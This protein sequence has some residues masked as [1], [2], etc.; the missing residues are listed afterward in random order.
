MRCNIFFLLF[1]FISACSNPKLTLDTEKVPFNELLDFI[2]AEQDKIQTLQ[3]ACRISVDSKEFSGN[4]F[5]SVNYTAN[6]S[7]HLSVSGPFGIQGG[8]LF[9]AKKR[10]VF[11]NQITNKFY[12]GTIDDFED[13]NFFQFPLNLK[14]LINIFSAKENL[15]SMKISSYRVD[16]DQFIIESYKQSDRY[17]ISVDPNFGHITRVEVQGENGNNIVREYSNFVK[18]KTVYFPRKIDM[19]RKD[20]NQAVSI[21]YTQFSLNERIEPARFRVKIA[22]TAEQMNYIH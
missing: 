14:E 11:Y 12:N 15:P 20:K 16:H 17:T 18:D 2:D 5:A 10:F 21:F 9:V 19:I 22:D 8:T 7:L 4:F 13:Q 6:D 1:I 3:A